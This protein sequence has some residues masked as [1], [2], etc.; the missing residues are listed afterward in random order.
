M[1][2]SPDG[3]S[4]SEVTIFYRLFYINHWNEG[5]YNRMKKIALILILCLPVPEASFAQN[6]VDGMRSLIVSSLMQYG[7]NLYDRGNF[8]DASAVF[9]HVLTY[10]KHQ[11]QALQ[12]LEVMGH[13]P[14]SGIAVDP[15]DTES[16]KQAIEAKKQSIKKLQAQIIRLRANI[17]SQSAAN[18]VLKREAKEQ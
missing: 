16:L 11:A 10:D 7:K 12:Y 5:T 1:L 6:N 15:A 17:A 2:Y 18:D 14:S 9:T 3:S 13:A 4:V 8:N